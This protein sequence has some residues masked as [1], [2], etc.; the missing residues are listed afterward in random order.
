MTTKRATNNIA[1]PTMKSG[2]SATG[3]SKMMG[4]EAAR[5]AAA[6]A[7]VRVAMMP[8]EHDMQ[9]TTR[10]SDAVLDQLCGVVCVRAATEVAVGLECDKPVALRVLN[11]VIL[12]GR[13]V[14]EAVVRLGVSVGVDEEVGA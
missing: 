5:A 7:E 12:A 1:A 11:A 3:T 8:A 9:R 10:V 2:S 14:D 6:R 4:R 13:D